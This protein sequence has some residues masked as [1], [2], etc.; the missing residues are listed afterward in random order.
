[1]IND[2]TLKTKAGFFAFGDAPPITLSSLSPFAVYALTDMMGTGG[3]IVR[4]RRDDT[5]AEQDFTEA[6]LYGSAYTTFI[7]SADAHIVTLYDQVG[8]RDISNSTAGN[9][10]KFTISTKS[11][12]FEADLLFSADQTNLVGGDFTLISKMD[13]EYGQG[14]STT[15]GLSAPLTM[16]NTTYG[17]TGW[18]FGSDHLGNRQQIEFQVTSSTPPNYYVAARSTNQAGTTNGRASVNYNSNPAALGFETTIAKCEGATSR[19]IEYAGLSASDSSSTTIGTTGTDKI[20]MNGWVVSGTQRAR[21]V[22]MHIKAGIIFNRILSD[23]DT[24]SIK[25]IMGGI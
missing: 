12:F 6:E 17:G 19:S 8:S 1:M 4:I 23:D 24:A 13:N 5:D 14:G 3:D 15:T 2:L 25:S 18:S 11:A 20:G 7:G 9:Q 10:P 22:N 16:Y 21:D